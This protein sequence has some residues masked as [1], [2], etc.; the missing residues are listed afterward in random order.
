MQRADDTE[1]VPL[2]T[3]FDLVL[4]GYDRDQVRQHLESIEEDIRMLTADRNETAAQVNDLTNRLEAARSKNEELRRKVDELCRP[5]MSATDLGDRL[6]RMLQ[7]ANTEASEITARAQAA[8]EHTWSSAEEAAANLR[9]RYQKMLDELDHQRHDMAEEHRQTME[10]AHAEVEEMTTKAERRRRELDGIAEKRRTQI[11]EEFETTMTKRR[12][13]LA[14]Q[15]AKEEAASKTAAEKRLREASEQA[16]RLLREK[17]EEAQRRIAE[18]NAE[19]ERL[20][21]EAKE[22]FERR[23]V[24][25]D[26]QYTALCEL[27]TKVAEQVNGALGL[28]QEASPLL[29]PLDEEQN[30]PVKQPTLESVSGDLELTG[31]AKGR[32]SQT[33]K[34]EAVRDKPKQEDRSPDVAETAKLKPVPSRRQGSQSGNQERQAANA[35]QR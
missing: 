21:K 9:S 10:R 6:N 2:K 20:V 29:V 31:T 13:E 8:A 22:D 15:V 16:E 25:A 11:E 27:R 3:T 23:V 24:Q 32:L 34:L 26:K 33:T 30:A 5:P 7:L 4:R 1:L 35:Q 17:T 14:E 12:A 28:M 19:A 18:A